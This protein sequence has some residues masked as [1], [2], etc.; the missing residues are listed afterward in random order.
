MMNDHRAGSTSTTRRTAARQIGEIAKLHP[1][2]LRPLLRQVRQFLRSKSWDTRV[3]AAQEIGAIA[4]N[5]S[6][7]I[8]KDIYTKAEVELAALGHNVNLSSSIDSCALGAPQSSTSL[9]FSR[10]V[11]SACIYL[12]WL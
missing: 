8:V 2:E 9:T 6:H 3:A 4:E 11:R 7:P 5:V 12:W 10:C 1:T